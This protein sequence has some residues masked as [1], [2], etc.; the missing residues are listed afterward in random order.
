MDRIRHAM[1]FMNEVDALGTVRE[2]KES[3]MQ[4]AEDETLDVEASQKSLKELIDRNGIEFYRPAR[5][6]LRN[7]LNFLYFSGMVANKYRAISHAMDCLGIIRWWWENHYRLKKSIVISAFLEGRNLESF[8]VTRMS[9][10]DIPQAIVGVRAFIIAFNEN[11][12]LIKWLKKQH[13]SNC[14]TCNDIV[15]VYYGGN[16]RR[17]E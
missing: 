8:G 13:R 4:N 5:M 3:L 7:L 17:I 15:R 11:T 12:E 16:P 14:R 2:L 10:C 9:Y 6:A 1:L